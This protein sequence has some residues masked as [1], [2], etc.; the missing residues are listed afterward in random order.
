M[1]KLLL[2]TRIGVSTKSIVGFL[3]FVLLV[4]VVW[5]DCWGQS[6]ECFTED[7]PAIYPTPNATARI[8]STLG[9][10][11]G[12]CLTYL[13]I[14]I[15]FIQRAD[16][17]GGYTPTGNDI[18]GVDE[19][20]SGYDFANDILEGMNYMLAN[21]RPRNLCNGWMYYTDPGH[22]FYDPAFE[23]PDPAMPTGIRLVV[24]EIR[25]VPTND[26][27]F[28]K[29]KLEFVVPELTDN[30]SQEINGTNVVDINYVHTNSGGVASGRNTYVSTTTYKIGISNSSCG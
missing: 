16:G 22:P 20:Y 9:V 15:N 8:N 27:V 30:F 11:E 18:S 21:N 7:N 26:D 25:F 24:N 13:K 4:F 14:N 2:H 12:C 29:S 28:G 6:M 17:S 3:I 23:M 1:R 10:E 19:C 5:E